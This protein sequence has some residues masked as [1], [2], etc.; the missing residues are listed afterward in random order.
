MIVF[1]PAGGGKSSSLDKYVN[2]FASDPADSDNTNANKDYS[3]TAANF[4]VAPPAGEKWVI[5]RMIA[6]LRDG[7]SIDSGAYGNGITL[8]NG[9]TMKVMRGAVEQLDMTAG[10]PVIINPDWTKLC[11]DA[12]IS[13]YGLGDETMAVRWTFSQSGMY[14]E[15]D[16]DQSDKIQIT[17]NDNLTGLNEHTFLFQGYKV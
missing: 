9:I 15:L 11:Y 2:V 5:S 6:Y 3:V 4:V 17:F 16:G 13:N 14:I 12:T 1:P 7:G 8:T 10:D